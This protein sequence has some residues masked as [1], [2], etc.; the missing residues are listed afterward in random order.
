MISRPARDY[1]AHEPARPRRL[2]GLRRRPVAEV[3]AQLGVAIVHGRMTCPA[4]GVEGRACSV[5]PDGMGWR[6]WACDAAGDALILAG[7]RVCGR[8]PAKGD[9]AAWEAISVALGGP[10]LDA[11]APKAQPVRA[12][13]RPPFVADVWDAC[14]NVVDDAEVAGWI[15]SRGLDPVALARR[16]IVRAWPRGR[17]GPAWMPAGRRAVF[18]GRDAAGDVVTLRF[19]GTLPKTRPPYEP[20]KHYD[21]VGAVLACPN[22]WALLTGV[23]PE[24]WDGRLYVAEGE[25]DFATVA[26]L[27]PTSAVWG[28]WSG[29][30]T[31][32]IARRVPEGCDVVIAVHH[33]K[34]GEKYAG[35]VRGSLE[36]RCDVTRTAPGPDENDRLRAKPE[37]MVAT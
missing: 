26:Q 21:A 17:R 12:L 22:G 20:G 2:D 3:A 29:S 7:Y 11:P 18:A 23:R 34:G 5:N 10:R 25:P 4:C 24:R 36:R 35:I 9:A 31:P 32:E 15:R 30:W 28:V 27:H 6:C 37:R 1:P 14:G 33:D 8:R 16:D 13:V 19:R